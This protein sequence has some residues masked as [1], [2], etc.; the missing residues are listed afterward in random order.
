MLPIYICEDEEA[1][2]EHIA[3]HISSFYAIHQEIEKPEI[4]TYSEPHGLLD[5][6]SG[7]TD[8]GIYLLDIRLNSDLNGLELAK[9]IRSLDPKGFIVFIT[10]HA[11]YAPKTFKLQVEA[12]GYINKDSPNL[13]ALIS[14]TLTRIHERYTTFQRS[15][16]DNPRLQFKSNRRIHY[17]FASDLIAIMTTEHSH[18]IKLFTV[19]GSIDFSGSLSKI[20]KNLPPSHF[21]QCHRSYII[22]KNHIKSYDADAHIIELT[23]QMQIPVSREKR[24][25][26]L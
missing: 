1:I 10:S 24:H 2:R 21:M 9:E 7:T 16:F 23:N 11:E 4:T 19:D 26:F 20:K 3:S 17:Y 8:M 14:T 25:L 15:S 18:R 13:N 12:F 6:L 5:S 22:N